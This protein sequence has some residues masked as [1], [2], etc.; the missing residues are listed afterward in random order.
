MCFSLEDVFSRI[1]LKFSF[2]FSLDSLE[3][4]GFDS[5]S[6]SCLQYRFDLQFAKRCLHSRLGLPT[7]YGSAAT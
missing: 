3:G 1:I 2:G 5:L 6:S 4:F 7:V